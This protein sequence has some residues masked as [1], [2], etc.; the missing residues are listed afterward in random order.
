MPGMRGW[1]WDAANSRLSLY[2]DDTEVARFDDTAGSYAKSL[3]GLKVEGEDLHIADGY[4]LKLGT[5]EE[6]STTAGTNGITFFAGTAPDGTCTTAC[7]LYSDG[8]GDDLSV[9]HADGTEDE[10]TT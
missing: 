1:K 6:F 4:N 10:L 9:E 5:T 2:V 3:S 7:Q 8:A